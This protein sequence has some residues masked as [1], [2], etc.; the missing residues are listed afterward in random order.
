MGRRQGEMLPAI[1]SAAWQWMAQGLELDRLRTVVR[2]LRGIEPARVTCTRFGQQ[3]R[4]DD[5]KL[6]FDTVNYR[7]RK[8]ADRGKLEQACSALTAELMD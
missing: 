1:L 4:H 6:L 2:S 7:D 3:H 5:L 8:E